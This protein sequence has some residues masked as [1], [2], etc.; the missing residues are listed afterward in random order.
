MSA[1]QPYAKLPSGAILEMQPTP[2]GRSGFQAV[3]EGD[4]GAAGGA[5]ESEARSWFG[6]AKTDPANFEMNEKRKVLVKAVAGEFLV[7][8]FFLFSVMSAGVNSMR[9]GN[10]EAVLPAIVTGFVGVALVYA[11]ADVSGAHFN[12]LVTF[13]TMV[14]GKTSVKKGLAYI[15]VQL[16]ASVGATLWL[17]VV[18]PAPV[19][20][21]APTAAQLAVVSVPPGSNPFNAF[22]MEL[23]LSGILAYTVFA[24]ALDT[25]DTTNRIAFAPSAP[26]DQSVGRNLTI[27]ATTG[28][29]KAGFAPIAIGLCLGALCLMGGSSSGGVFNPA[30]AFG[31]ALVS[32]RWE[33]QWLYWIADLSGAAVAALV[34]SL[35]AHKAVQSS[36]EATAGSS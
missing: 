13:A 3:R 8:F 23:T 7:T 30:R 35:L 15:F 34:Q 5:P 14:T 11:F 20:A 16:L 2:V 19:V 36:G 29:S 10:G 6:G 17:R 27:Y 31:P 18:F 4:G 21:G 25:V 32:G 28:N 12:P 26:L 22:L 33:Y 1:P 24:T 9:S